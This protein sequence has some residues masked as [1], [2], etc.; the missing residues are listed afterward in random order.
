MPALSEK[1]KQHQVKCRIASCNA[2]C[3]GTSTTGYGWPLDI[4]EEKIKLENQQEF[5]EK[6]KETF[7]QSHKMKLP[8]NFTFNC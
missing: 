7:L 6:Q 5:Y 3:N 8:E 2:L 4:L 1:C